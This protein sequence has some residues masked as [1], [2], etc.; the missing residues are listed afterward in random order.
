[1]FDSPLIQASEAPIPVQGRGIVFLRDD[2]VPCVRM[3]DGTV[4]SMQGAPGAPGAQGGA[5]PAGAVGPQGPQGAPGVVWNALSGLSFGSA[6]SSVVQAVGAYSLAEGIMSVRLNLRVG[7]NTLSNGP[8]DFAVVQ[9]LPYWFKRRF[10]AVGS[11]IHQQGGTIEPAYIRGMQQEN[12]LSV[13]ST[14]FSVFVWSA[15]VGWDL[16]IEFSAPVDLFPPEQ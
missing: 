10:S 6:D 5:G 7:A 4:K 16:N 13:V 1:M 3:H 12:A 9:G 14:S 15:I 8:A 11:I 2:G